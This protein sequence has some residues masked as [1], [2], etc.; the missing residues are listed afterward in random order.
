MSKPSYTYHKSVV[1]AI[2]SLNNSLN[3]SFLKKIV[4]REQRNWQEA[5]D[6]KSEFLDTIPQPLYFED[7][8]DSGF[9]VFNLLEGQRRFSLKTSKPILLDLPD[10]FRSSGYCSTELQLLA[11]SQFIKEKFKF[12]KDSYNQDLEL[13]LALE[14]RLIIQLV[15][16]N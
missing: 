9:K 16:L 5:I 13:V 2:S 6:K 3:Q 14:G 7:K 11:T 8:K 15:N 12:L 1:G 10:E 4:K